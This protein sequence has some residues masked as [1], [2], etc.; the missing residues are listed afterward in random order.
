M[1]DPAPTHSRLRSARDTFRYHLDNLFARGTWVV[2][3][4]L[5]A[6]TLAAILLS[7]VLLTATRVTFSGSEST[8]WLEDFWQS[9]LRVIDPG[10]MAADVGWGQRLLALT[11]TLFGLLVAGTLIGL[12]ANGVEQY[13]DRLRRGRST[14]VESG[15]VVILGQSDRLPVIVEQVALA[16]RT[17]RTNT[18]VVLSDREPDALADDVRAAAGDLLGTRLVVRRGDPARISDLEMVA[19]TRART[20]IALADDEDDDAGR[21]DARVVKA[22]LAS[23]AALGGFDRVPIVAEI[24][25]PLTAVTLREASGPAVQPVTAQHTIARITAFALREPGINQVLEELLDLQGADIHL[26][27]VGDLV[28]STF[29]E[30]VFCFPDARPIGR[31]TSDGRIELAPEPSTVLE[32]TDRLI[33]IADD[34]RAPR[35]VRPRRAPPETIERVGDVPGPSRERL[36]AIGWSLIGAHLLSNLDEFVAPGST[37][38]IVYDTSLFGDEL[39]TLP[40]LRNIEATVTPSHGRGL[41]ES[42]EQH[43]TSIVMLGYRRGMSVDEADSRTLLNLLALRRGDRHGDGPRPRIVVELRDAGHVELAQLLGADDQVVSDALA[44]RVM[45]QLAEQPQREGVLR[46]LYDAEGPSLRLAPATEF[47]LSGTTVFIDIVAAAAE[48][49]TLALGWRRRAAAGGQVVLN[50]ALTASVDLGPN[51]QVLVIQPETPT[52]DP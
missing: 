41:H 22:V 4:W 44:S 52:T 26:H 24:A 19:I 23:G 43:P 30:A 39:L 6:I 8:S 18:V 31:R 1:A 33:L 5:G 10:T 35:R 46:S 45:V 34:E 25:D 42:R 13:V 32:A 40:P 28:G 7:S 49:G 29:G 21:G 15:H 9:L 36:V 50:P 14:V 11:I 17:R 16:N 38:E 47:G 51:D 48:R 3:L 20:V 2:L 12:I 27:D 37:A